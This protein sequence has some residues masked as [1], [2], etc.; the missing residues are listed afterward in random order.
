MC[1]TNI[2]RI[3]KYIFLNGAKSYHFIK[4]VWK[5][6]FEI[7]FWGLEEGGAV[8]LQRNPQWLSVSDFLVGTGTS[9]RRKMSSVCLI[10]YK[11]VKQK[12]KLHAGDALIQLSS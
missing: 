2:H 10:I 5:S 3:S 11:H 7:S 4:S 8:T 6:E 1:S 12:I 9:G